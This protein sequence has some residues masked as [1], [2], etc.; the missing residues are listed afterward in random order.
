[1]ADKKRS[2]KKR[3]KSLN[4]KAAADKM[5]KGATLRNIARAAGSQAAEQNLAAVGLAI[6]KKLRA[7][8]DF[9]SAFDRL[10]YTVDRFAAD[11]VES[12]QAV[13]TVGVKDEA[14]AEGKKRVE[15][16][17][18]DHPTRIAARNQYLN[19]IGLN[20]L[21]LE[22][23]DPPSVGSGAGEDLLLKVALRTASD[24]EV[25]A[26]LAAGSDGTA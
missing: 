9:Q 8:A 2:G 22:Q 1:M 7:R 24:E 26:F 23:P 25:A 12:C 18:P 3:G 5:T 13:K 11:V 16:T 6:V 21:P 4:Y 20:Q 15:I 14:D 10:G 19:A 17:I